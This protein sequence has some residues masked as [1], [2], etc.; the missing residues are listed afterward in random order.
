MS[1]AVIVGMLS[2][3][4]TVAGTLGGIMATQRLTTYK[5]EQLQQEVQKHNGLIDR[6]Y[7]LEGQMKETQ[8]DIRDIKE[9]IERM[10]K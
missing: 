5:I 2:L 6:T 3:I 8:H 7:R 9:R 10:N 1:D 4:G